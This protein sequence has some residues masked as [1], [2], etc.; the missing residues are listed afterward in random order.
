MKMDTSSRGRRP[1]LTWRWRDQHLPVTRFSPF[2]TK[3]RRFGIF[4]L[5]RQATSRFRGDGEMGDR[6]FINA[7]LGGFFLP[8]PP[9]GYID[10]QTWR[11]GEV[12]SSSK[13]EAS[14]MW[15]RFMPRALR[16]KE[17]SA[18]NRNSSSRQL[19]SRPDDFRRRRELRYFSAGRRAA[20]SREALI[21]APRGVDIAVLQPQRSILERGM[22]AR[23]TTA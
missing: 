3:R 15:R 14:V 23:S 10:R 21:S 17:R 4:H 9:H 13:G 11:H 16:Y 8:K 1:Q 18:G 6:Y 2:L 19:E 7:H 22:T 12:F 20:D 5:A